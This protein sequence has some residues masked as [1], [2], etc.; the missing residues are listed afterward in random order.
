MEEGLRYFLLCV[1]TA[2]ASPAQ[3]FTTL[4]IFDFSDG[5]LP[6]AGLIQA[7]DGNLYGTTFQ[8]GTNGGG[9]AFKI[10]PSGTLK[11]LYNFC[12]LSGCADGNAL[13]GGL[14]QVDNGNL[15]GTT[16]QGGPN[17]GSGT[18]FK[19]TLS[20]TLTTL[21]N[22]DT[23]D[24]RYPYAGLV[25]ASNGNF[26][27]T[28]DFGGANSEGAVFKITSTGA[29]TTLHSFANTDGIQPQ[30]GLVQASNGNL[31]GTTQGGGTNNEGT[32]FKITPG[33]TLTSLHS[34]CSQTGCPYGSSP[35]AGLVQATDGTSTGRRC[36][37]GPAARARSSRLPQ[38]AR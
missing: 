35:Y 19:I 5:S 20:G 8:G 27:G 18:V 22:F 1:T 23:T 2:I 37:E 24:G 16:Q 15:Y 34:F 9:T 4:H 30:S 31:Y 33:G 13:S 3:T 7:A 12:S 10:T 36:W 14:V 17:N 25:Q 6:Y 38:A 28:T 32:V 26:Y 11:T 21:H 29:L